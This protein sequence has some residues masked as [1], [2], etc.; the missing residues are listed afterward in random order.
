MFDLPGLSRQMV[1]GPPLQDPSSRWRLPRAS[2][3]PTPLTSSF[4]HKRKEAQR[5]DAIVELVPGA[6][7]VLRHFSLKCHCIGGSQMYGTCLDSVLFIYVLLVYCRLGSFPEWNYP[8][9]TMGWTMDRIVN[10]CKESITY[11]YVLDWLVK[12]TI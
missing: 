3:N 2:P 5:K 9:G 10:F 7:P 1:V 4:H 12:L 8:D 6:A 11:H